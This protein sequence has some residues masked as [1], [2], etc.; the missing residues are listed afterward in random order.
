MIRNMGAVSKIYIRLLSI[1]GLS[2]LVASLSLMSF[3]PKSITKLGAVRVMPLGD[4]ITQGDQFHSSYRRPLWKL[5]S[6][7]EMNIDF[8]GSGKLNF[9]Q[10]LP[11][12][13]DFDLDNEGHWG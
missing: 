2:L 8:V 3:Q 13:P 1:V 4:S 11:P 12:N 5:I 6:E 9:P 10:H 7:Q